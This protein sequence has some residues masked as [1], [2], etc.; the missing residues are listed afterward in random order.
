[1]FVVIV[2]VV[3]YDFVEWLCDEVECECCEC[4]EVV[5]EWGGVGWKEYVVEY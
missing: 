2:D 3:E 4:G 5:C 1:M